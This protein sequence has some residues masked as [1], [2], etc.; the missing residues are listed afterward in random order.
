[1]YFCYVNMCYTLLYYSL[2]IYVRITVL[3]HLFRPLRFQQCFFAW[4]PA[5]YLVQG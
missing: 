2:N 1:M 3:Y 5:A 4:M